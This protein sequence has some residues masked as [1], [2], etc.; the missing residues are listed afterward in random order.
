MEERIQEIWDTIKDQDNIC[1]RYR[2]KFLK[3]KKP[4]SKGQKIFS[5]I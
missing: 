5:T 3:K 4:K 2:K 1:N